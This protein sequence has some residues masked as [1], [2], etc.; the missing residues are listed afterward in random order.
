MFGIG[1]WLAQK[2]TG[3]GRPMGLVLDFDDRHVSYLSCD[4]RGGTRDVV[5]GYVY[6]S[7]QPYAVYYASCYPSHGE[8][9][10]DVILGT[11][12]DEIEEA[13]DRVTFGCRFGPV[14]GQTESACSLVP[15]AAMA[16]E[17]V[18]PLFGERL[19]RE[20][21]QKHPWLGEFWEVVD[22]VILTDPT[23]HPCQHPA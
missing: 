9:Y 13:N 16:P 18:S 15:G 5:T 1:R 2:L 21:A 4:D 20:Q 3:R 10:I 19:D 7:R 11:W 12:P 23:V 17:P 14:E 8:V 22:L 6:R